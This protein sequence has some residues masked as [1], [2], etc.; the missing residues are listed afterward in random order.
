M[1]FI[2]IGLKGSGKTILGKTVAK[3]L[4]KKFVD[5]DNMIEEEYGR[6]KDSK[7][8]FREIYNLEGEEYFRKLEAKVYQDLDKIENSIISS[9]GS[10]PRNPHVNFEAN[11]DNLTVIYVY[12]SK[13]ILK[14]RLLEQ[15]EL[16]AFFDKDDFDGSFE[17][18]WQE[19]DSFYRKTCD[20]IF[21]NS[22]EGVDHAIAK[23]Y[24]RLISG[25]MNQNPLEAPK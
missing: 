23:F 1:N 10:L 22:N 17:K 18:M 16:P 3:Q 12:V 25:M 13:E 11:R 19:R 6:E 14:E 2:L 8:T 24:N 7:Y 9:G 5:T 15:K 4:N 20:F 21:D